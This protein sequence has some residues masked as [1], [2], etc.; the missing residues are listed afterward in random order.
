MYLLPTYS[1]FRTPTQLLSHSLSLV[2]QRKKI[3]WETGTRK[4]VGQHRDRR[5]FTN[6]CHRQNQLNLGKINFIFCQLKFCSKKKK[7]YLLRLQRVSC[8]TIVSSIG[9]RRTSASA[10]QASPALSPS[11]TLECALFSPLLLCLTSIFCSFLNTF[12]HWCHQLV[13]V[14]EWGGCGTYRNWLELAGTSH[15]QLG[16]AP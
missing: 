8:S 4:T 14:P 13:C 10:P 5:S 7:A 3:K 12:S 1:L 2:G 15:V 16:A 11:L 9:G 6:Y